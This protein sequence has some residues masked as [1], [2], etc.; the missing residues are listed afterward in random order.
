MYKQLARISD[1]KQQL[2]MTGYHV[3]QLDHIVREVI[4]DSPLADISNEQ[5]CELVES[6][7]Y[8]CDFA[9]KCKTKKL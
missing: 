9:R 1:L 8:Y 6:L 5:C 2:L 4:G 3:T 7:E